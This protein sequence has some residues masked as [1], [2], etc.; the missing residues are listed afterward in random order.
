MACLNQGSVLHVIQAP[1]LGVGRPPGLASLL[2]YQVSFCMYD[3]LN[4]NV[5]TGIS[6]GER[7]EHRWSARFAIARSRERQDL[8]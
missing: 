2:I 7:A 4:T 6:G 3:S 1:G 8:A 5:A